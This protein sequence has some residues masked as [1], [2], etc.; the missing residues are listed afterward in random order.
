[1]DS[2]CAHT[3]DGYGSQFPAIFETGATVLVATAGSPADYDIDLEAL[4]TFGTGL[5]TA[6][7]VTTATPATE[8]IEAFAARTGVSERPALKLVDATGTRPAY[9]A[10]YDEIPILSTTGPDDLERLL[11]AL[12]DLT[13]SSVRSPARRHLVVRSLSPL[14]EANP[15]KRITTV[16]ERIRAYRSSSGLCL[17]GFDY[18]NHDESTLATLSDHVDGILWIRELAADQPAFDYE[19]MTHQL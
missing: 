11:V 18:T 9:G 12:A 7:V 2:S 10:P 6:I 13:E 19:P 4:A 15:V 17:F 3:D 14:L 16:L 5:D 8:T 1:M